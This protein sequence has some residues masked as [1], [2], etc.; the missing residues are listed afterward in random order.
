MTDQNQTWE[1]RKK[2]ARKLIRQRDEAVTYKT[3]GYQVKVDNYIIY[4]MENEGRITYLGEHDPEGNY[5]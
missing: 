5:N 1:A 3:A 2:E 4:F